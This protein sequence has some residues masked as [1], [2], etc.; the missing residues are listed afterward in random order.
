VSWVSWCGYSDLSFALE[1]EVTANNLP[2]SLT[3]GT[4][5]QH[6]GSST[7]PHLFIHALI[8]VSPCMQIQLTL[9]HL[10]VALEHRPAP[11][12]SKVHVL[13]NTVI[14]SVYLDHRLF[15]A[16]FIV[17]SIMMRSL[18]ERTRILI[19]SRWK[20]A[21]LTSHLHRR[22]RFVSVDGFEGNLKLHL[23]RVVY[24]VEHMMLKRLGERLQG[25]LLG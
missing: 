18:A 22:E 12:L 20:Q 2:T 13:T 19:S 1:A 4:Q 17:G 11:L 5:T 15:P 23:C 21:L 8:P 3:S 7:T 24:T 25:R 6:L 10:V 9:G 16:V 14:L